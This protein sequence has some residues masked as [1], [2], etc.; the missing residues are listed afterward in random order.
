[1]GLQLGR[2]GLDFKRRSTGQKLESDRPQRVTVGGRAGR[3]AHDR[4]RRQV[5]GPTDRL[6]WLPRGLDPNRG[7][8]VLERPSYSEAVQEHLTPVAD[9]HV[10]RLHVAVDDAAGMSVVEHGRQRRQH[11]HC[12]SSRPRLSEQVV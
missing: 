6:A 5:P 7:A 11:K 2:P 8:R 4:L 1:L 3:L 9:Q 10:Q 12:L